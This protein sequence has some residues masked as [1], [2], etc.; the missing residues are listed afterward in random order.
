MIRLL[1]SLLCLFNFTFAQGYNFLFVFFQKGYG[2]T[3]FVDTNI[4]CDSC[5]STFNKNSFNQ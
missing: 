2:D 1:I 3:A 4:Y 5:Y